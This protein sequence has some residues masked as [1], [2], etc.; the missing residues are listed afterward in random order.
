MYVSR[1]IFRAVTG[2]TYISM[3][4]GL[5]A[6]IEHVLVGVQ[7]LDATIKSL[8]VLHGLTAGGYGGAVIVS[9]LSPTYALRL[10]EN[11]TDFLIQYITTDES[12]KNLYLFM[13]PSGASLVV[14]KSDHC[15]HYFRP[16]PTCEDLVC[17]AGRNESSH[18]ALGEWI[19]FA[20]NRTAS[21]SG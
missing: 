7:N 17:S 8:R 4:V 16:N 11:H 9:V 12:L 13:L 3:S 6:K 1:A 14:S 19:H 2:L 5:G 20:A 15:D 18:S 21:S 10:C